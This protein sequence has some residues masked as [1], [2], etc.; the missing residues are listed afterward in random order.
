M[1][2][3]RVQSPTAGLRLAHARSAR[4]AFSLCV[5]TDALLTNVLD[6][7]RLWNAS[8]IG[9]QYVLLFDD[10]NLSLVDQSPVVFSQ[11]RKSTCF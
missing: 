1:G 7:V 2:P 10:S 9:V 3:Q 11:R 4:R 6:H 5:R 8:E